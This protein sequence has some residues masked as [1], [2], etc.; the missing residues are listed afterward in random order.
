MKKH[1]VWGMNAHFLTYVVLPLPFVVLS[2][3]IFQ[4]VNQAAFHQSSDQAVVREPGKRTL[5]PPIE[6]APEARHGLQLALLSEAA[7]QEK[8]GP[9]LS[10]NGTVVDAKKMLDSKWIKWEDFPRD[11][12]M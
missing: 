9:R 10:K 6:A 5:G 11:E 4:L 8:V 1:R 3:F 2:P 7:Y 12:P